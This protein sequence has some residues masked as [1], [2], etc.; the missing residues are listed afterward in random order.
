MDPCSIIILKSSMNFLSKKDFSTTLLWPFTH[1]HMERWKDSSKT[2]NKAE[3]IAS[4]REEMRF[5]TCLSPTDP[6]CTQLQG[7]PVR[8]KVNYIEPEP[9]R[10]EKDDIICCR[11]AV[12]K[13]KMKT[14]ENNLL[15]GDNVLV[16]QQRQ[17][18]WSTPYAPVF[19]VECSIRA[20]QITA[21]RATDGQTACRDARRFKIA[22]A[23]MNQR[24]VEVQTPQA[25]PD[26]QIP[27]KGPLPS[28]PHA[29]IIPEQ[30]AEHNQQ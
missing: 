4:L 2:L 8:K 30:G 14:R 23:V 20:P 25:V 27:E 24:S 13:Q 29:E 21:R 9:Q 3:Q 17:N 5:K 15:L 7:V 11:D 16:K 22:N 1:E 28:V 26:L 6:H 12:Y 10:N 18:K 19:Y